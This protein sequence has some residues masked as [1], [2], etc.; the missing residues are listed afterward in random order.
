MSEI[1]HGAEADL[2]EWLLVYDRLN[3][4]ASLY[5]FFYSYL[6]FTC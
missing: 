6:I 5:S 2:G 1:V 3:P 4:E